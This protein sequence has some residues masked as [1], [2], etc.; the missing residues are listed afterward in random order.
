MGLLISDNM[1]IFTV[2]FF[3]HRYID[4]MNRVERRLQEF[5][6][7][8]LGR[9]EYVEFL[10]GRNGEFD[11]LVSSSVRI[12]KREMRDDNSSLTLVLPYPTAEYM[13]NQES[14]DAYYD[15]IELCEDS[16]KTHFKGAIQ[17]RNQCMIDRADLIVVYVNHPSGGAYRA[18]RYAEK[19]EKAIL[20]L[21]EI[22][23]GL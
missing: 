7:D 17:K 5:I 8:L 11:Q 4:D 9:K 10:V 14:F 12:A 23:D 1:E 20:N 18:M 21:V 3:G 19:R 15:T 13:K 16:D 6:R 2:A 22:V